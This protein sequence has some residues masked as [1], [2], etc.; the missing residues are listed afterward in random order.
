MKLSELKKSV[1]AMEAKLAESHPGVDPVVALYCSGEEVMEMASQGATLWVRGE[2]GP[3]CQGDGI[4]DLTSKP[5][6]VIIQ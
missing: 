6:A 1:E 2:E 4:E 3:Y 5:V